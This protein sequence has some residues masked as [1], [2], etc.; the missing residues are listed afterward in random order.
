MNNW[1]VI[2]SVQN[3]ETAL[4]QPVPI[5]GLKPVHKTSFDALQPGDT[6]WFYATSPVAGVIGLGL[7]K[8]KYFDKNNLIWHA[9]KKER[10][11]IWPYRFRFQVLKVVDAQHW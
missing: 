4:S 9:E 6:I 3:W 7:V 10:N 1:L 11:V 8:D 2:G 5:W